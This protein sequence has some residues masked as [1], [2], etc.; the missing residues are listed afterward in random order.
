[1]I[2]GENLKIMISFISF[3]RLELMKQQDAIQW[4]VNIKAAL[5]K[6]PLSLGITKDATS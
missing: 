1:M 3:T 5:Q 6:L 4:I 2:H